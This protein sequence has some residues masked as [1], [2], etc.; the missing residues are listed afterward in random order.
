MSARLSR[1]EFW[2]LGSVVEF[3]LG[4]HALVRPNLDQLLNKR[5]HGLPASQLADM[6]TALLPTAGSSQ[7]SRS[8]TAKVVRST[9]PVSASRSR[10]TAT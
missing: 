1:A 9:G 6:M 8:V 2:L 10:S 7:V 3:R 5:P 4:I